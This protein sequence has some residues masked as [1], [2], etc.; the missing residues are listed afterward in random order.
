MNR[1]PDGDPEEAPQR[2][3]PVRAIVRA[4]RSKPR[5]ALVEPVRL[6]GAR[7]NMNTVS[8]TVAAASRTHGLAMISQVAFPSTTVNESTSEKPRCAAHTLSVTGQVASVAVNP[9]ICQSRRWIIASNRKGA[10]TLSTR[11]A[12]AILARAC[13]RTKGK[14]DAQVDFARGS[15]VFLRTLRQARH[16]CPQAS[17][18]RTAACLRPAAPSK[19]PHK[20]CVR[21]VGTTAHQLLIRRDER[22]A[23]SLGQR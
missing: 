14:R 13:K 12:N 23:A 9:A 16:G 1:Q 5:C 22:R 19:Q 6:V 21:G 10:A 2:A 3:P 15:H 20:L 8:A 17:A 4:G 18:G 11:I 7:S